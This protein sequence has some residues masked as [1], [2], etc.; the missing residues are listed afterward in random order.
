M[1][2]ASP[3]PRASKVPILTMAFSICKVSIMLLF[4]IM[5]SFLAAKGFLA[6]RLTFLI[7]L[8][9]GLMARLLESAEITMT[10]WNSQVPQ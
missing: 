8:S 1:L 7:I 10:A 2:P 4:F 6:M 3:K 5:L 9:N